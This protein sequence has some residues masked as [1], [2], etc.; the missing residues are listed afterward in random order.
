MKKKP[1]KLVLAKETV[2]SLEAMLG[3]AAGAGIYTY[4]SVCG[5]TGTQIACGS[6][7]TTCG[8]YECLDA[9]IEP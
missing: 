9:C 6:G 3:E 5:G 4:C 2:R 1:K 8:R 7:V